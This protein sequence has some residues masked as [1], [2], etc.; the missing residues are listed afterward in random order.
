LIAVPAPVVARRPVDDDERARGRKPAYQPL[1]DAMAAR[2]SG[3][4][5][6]DPAAAGP[7]L[8]QTGRTAERSFGDS[9]MS[10]A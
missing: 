9:V 5:Y 4:S 7:A 1:R 3:A 10:R 2:A 6:G 8:L